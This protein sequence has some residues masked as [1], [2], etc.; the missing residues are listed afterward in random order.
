M[1]CESRLRHSG[2]AADE[3]TSRWPLDG[4]MI[5]LVN[6]R[7]IS[8]NK[9]FQPPQNFPAE[10]TVRK[11]LYNEAECAKIVGE[12]QLALSLVDLLRSRSKEL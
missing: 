1:S 9:T 8:R 5:G 6:R 2:V 10:S 11:E 12:M 4:A 3:R 7:C